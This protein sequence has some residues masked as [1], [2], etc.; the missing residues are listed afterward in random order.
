MHNNS[1]LLAFVI[2]CITEKLHIPLL[3]SMGIR[4]V[5]YVL[6]N[7]TSDTCIEKLLCYNVRQSEAV[8]GDP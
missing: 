8:N 5:S 1:Y 6:S 3:Q 4:V 7:S 2:R